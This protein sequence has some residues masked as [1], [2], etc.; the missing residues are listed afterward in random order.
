MTVYPSGIAFPFRFSPAGGVQKAE[1]DRK[2]ISNLSALVLSEV[3]SR[4]IR[5]KVGTV[6]YSRVLRSAGLSTFAP[7]E[8]LFRQAIQKYEP[9]ATQVEVNLRSED[10]TDGFRV[11]AEIRFIFKNTGEAV[12][13]SL[14][15]T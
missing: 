4:L 3:R 10:R 6:G 2:V 8:H 12:K 7:I 1:G 13:L 5:K 15:L 9:R 14:E 11:I